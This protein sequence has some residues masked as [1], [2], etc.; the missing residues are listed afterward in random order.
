MIRERI[1][2]QRKKAMR[3]RVL[4]QSNARTVSAS[5]EEKL[6]ELRR[7]LKLVESGDLVVELGAAKTGL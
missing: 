4:R 5:T 1:E 3:D 7:L 2:A 6:V